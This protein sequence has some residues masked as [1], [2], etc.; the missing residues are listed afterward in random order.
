MPAATAPAREITSPEHTLVMAEIMV[1]AI[2]AAF[3]IGQPGFN[4]DG[5]LDLDGD[6]AK[7]EIRDESD[8]IVYELTLRPVR[9]DR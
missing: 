7:T 1:S 3:D 2:D 4:A 5:G 8:G 6:T 9:R